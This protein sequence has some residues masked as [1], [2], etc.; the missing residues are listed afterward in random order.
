MKDWLQDTRYIVMPSHHPTRGFEKEYAQAYQCWKT[1]WVKLCKDIG[2]KAPL[3][4]DG[5]LMTDE[6]GVIFYK[7][8]CVGLS[9]FTYGNLLD[10]PIRDL[11]WFGDWTEADY[12]KLQAISENNVICS[13]FSV[14]PFF[15]GKDQVVRWKEILALYTQLRFLQ[16]GADVMAGHLNLTKGMQNGAGE[17]YGATV[18][19]PLHAHNFAGVDLSA[20]LVAYEKPILQQMI[21]KKGLTELTREMLMQVVHLSSFEM[22]LPRREFKIAA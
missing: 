6:I 16:S 5:L 4:S 19:N 18:I 14:S 22:V 21:Q 7:D 2:V 17:E 1:A 13:Q 8:E 9:A 3:Y 10:S 15:C 12:Q 20:Q 11:S